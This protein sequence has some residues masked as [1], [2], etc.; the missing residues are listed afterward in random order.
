MTTIILALSLLLP[1]RALTPG[2][3]AI[4]P[5]TNKTWTAA[6]LCS[7]T[8]RTKNYRSVTEKV[9]VEV[10][11]RYG[12]KPSGHYEVDHLISI[13][14][15][16]SNDIENLWPESYLTTPLNATRKDVL[17][18]R[19]HHLVCVGAITLETAQHEI[20]TDWT[21]SYRKRIQ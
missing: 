11:T 12:L 21:A 14:L 18:N 17:E 1:N 7:P 13:E 20:A 15:G 2:K 6:D 16:G 9:H 5:A 19:L 8:Y 3:L 4:N 10:F